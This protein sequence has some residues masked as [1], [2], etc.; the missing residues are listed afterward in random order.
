M[1]NVSHIG[2]PWEFVWLKC[3]CIFLPMTQICTYPV[4][5]LSFS[6]G[7]LRTKLQPHYSDDDTLAAMGALSTFMRSHD[8]GSG[9]IAL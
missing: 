9:N 1:K 6:N 3:F 7:L 5:N 8:K 4:N 2:L